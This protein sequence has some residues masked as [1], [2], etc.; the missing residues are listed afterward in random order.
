ME[1]NKTEKSYVGYVGTRFYI[2]N[3]KERIYTVLGQDEFYIKY[4]T[5][6]NVLKTL[7]TDAEK[8]FETG[9]W[10]I[11]PEKISFAFYPK[12]DTLEEL[13]KQHSA[14]EEKIRAIDEMALVKKAL[15]ELQ[16]EDEPKGSVYTN[17]EMVE[18]TMHYSGMSKEAVERQIERYFVK[19]LR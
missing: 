7:V 12:E 10:V 4:L 9:K 15:E 17:K 8:Y 3:D 18:F 11:V 1:E 6:T 5:N 14:I 16:G 2:D 13:L 19:G